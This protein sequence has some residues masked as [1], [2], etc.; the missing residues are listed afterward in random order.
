VNDYT[1]DD[2]L[3][4]I[5]FIGTLWAFVY[6]IEKVIVLYISVHY[7][8][9]SDF[10]RI[11]RSK[12]MQTALST[13]YEASLQLYPAYQEP[14]A[15]EDYIIRHFT[16]LE[17]NNPSGGA[18]QFLRKLGMAGDK[19]TDIL[20]NVLNSGSQSHWFKPDVPYAIVGHALEHPRSAAALATRIWQSLVSEGND[21]L[22]VDD[23]AEVLGP[24]KREDAEKFFK[25]LDEN[26]NKDIELD[27][28]AMTVVELGRIR[29]AIF[30]GM[31]DMNHAINTF[32][33]IALT[34]IAFTMIFF[35]RKS[36]CHRS[37]LECYN[38]DVFFLGF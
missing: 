25:I 38:R 1:W 24:H 2:A 7:H 22:T 11:K 14:F 15:T 16:A 18:G 12:A 34:A 30:Q 17:E 35:I 31:N 4:I 21:K 37:T 27:E 32:D 26:E 29:H 28:L 3:N 33:W 36:P 13:L 8:Y 9:R 19:I 23:I 10:D 6:L 20:G 5:L